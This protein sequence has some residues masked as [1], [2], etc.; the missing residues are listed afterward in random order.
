MSNPFATIPTD[1]AA[2][3]R[4]MAGR[5]MCAGSQSAGKIKLREV[6]EATA[7]DELYALLKGRPKISSD[8]LVAVIK[9]GGKNFVLGPIQNSPQ[10]EI[11][12]D[13][14]IVGEKGFNSPYSEEPVV[15]NSAV[16]ASTSSISAYSVNV[17]NTSFD[18]PDGTWTVDA[19]GGGFYAHSSDNGAVR[20]HLQVGNDAGTALA[21]AC[22]QDPGRTYIG[23]ANRAVGQTG[24]IEIRQEYRPNVSG[25]A[26]AGGGWL[27]ALG[28]RT[29]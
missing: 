14:P 1:V 20:V 28:F 22:R 12:Y 11:T 15:S 3:I 24:S 6:F 16:V 17:Q 7:G 13:L 19:W 2:Q 18:L 25:T 5:V 9:L 26:Y 23:L 4:A 21:I 10:T 8:D 27:M 29:A